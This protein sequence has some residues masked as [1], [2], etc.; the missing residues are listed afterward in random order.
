M[1][2]ELKKLLRGRP[3]GHTRLE[4]PSLACSLPSALG[5]QQMLADED[6]DFEESSHSLNFSSEV[7]KGVLGPGKKGGKLFSLISSLFFAIIHLPWKQTQTFQEPLS[8]SMYGSESAGAMQDISPEVESL[9]CGKSHGSW[10]LG[11]RPT[12][13]SSVLCNPHISLVLYLGFPGVTWDQSD[14]RCLV[15]KT[16]VLN[17]FY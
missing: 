17:P 11:P 16:I 9:G 5:S 15:A 12:S 2:T 4:S 1:L 3:G 14:L 7:W 13:A 6:G 10:N 8:E